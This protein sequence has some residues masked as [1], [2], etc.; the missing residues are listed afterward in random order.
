LTGA[1]APAAAEHGR[2]ATPILDESETTVETTSHWPPRRDSV[3]RT[4]TFYVLNES[5]QPAQ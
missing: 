5:Q 1:A 4:R 3:D 2:S